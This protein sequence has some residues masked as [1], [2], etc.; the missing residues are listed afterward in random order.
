MLEALLYGLTSG[1]AMCL[2]L[3]TVFFALIQNSVDN[4]YR[5]GMKIAL[6]VVTCDLLFILFALF[7]T[8]LLPQVDHFDR[9]LRLS[10]AALLLG[11]GSVS[12]LRGTPKLAYPQ[13]RLGTFV[14][15]F[16]KGF[17]L[18]ALNPINFFIWV[19]VAALV[20]RYDSAQTAVFFGACLMAIFG[21][22]TIISLSA[23]HL[24]HRFSAR[25]LG[26]INKV[27]G[28]VFIVVGL[29]LAWTQLKEWL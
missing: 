13:T 2:S 24:K 28:L 19:S 9:Y 12:L 16:G 10:C 26:A 23:H 1:V 5:S 17:F 6:G 27:S 29:N 15:Y 8:A 25:V 14:Y 4:G 3:G 7:G 11:L 22:E 20:R 18:N 21:T